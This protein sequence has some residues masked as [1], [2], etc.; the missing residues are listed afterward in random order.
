MQGFLTVVLVVNATGIIMCY[1]HSLGGVS[2]AVSATLWIPWHHFLGKTHMLDRW[3]GRLTLTWANPALF[4]VLWICPSHPPSLPFHLCVC[5]C[6]CL[7]VSASDRPAVCLGT[8][9]VCRQ[10]NV[11]HVADKTGDCNAGCSYDLNMLAKAWIHA[12]PF[13]QINNTTLEQ[14]WETC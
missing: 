5:V 14:C 1:T 13:C 11:P 9:P 7:C 12:T 6:A 10:V 2:L 4:Q 8:V 3:P